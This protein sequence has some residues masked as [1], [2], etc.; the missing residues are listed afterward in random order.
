MQ[1]LAVHISVTALHNLGTLVV[2]YGM[3]AGITTGRSAC[4]LL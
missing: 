3:H 4:M 2:L 1:W